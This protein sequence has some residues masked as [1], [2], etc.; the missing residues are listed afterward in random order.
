MRG[1][2]KFYIERADFENA[3]LRRQFSVSASRLSKLG[4]REVAIAR[5]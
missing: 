2:P 3:V 1:L 4:P 5:L